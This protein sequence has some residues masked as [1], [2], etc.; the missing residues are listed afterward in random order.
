MD[1]GIR[2]GSLTGIAGIPVCMRNETFSAIR[3]LA[4][5]LLEGVDLRQISGLTPLAFVLNCEN[6]IR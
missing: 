3:T 2:I 5:E 1:Q 4:Q 6:V